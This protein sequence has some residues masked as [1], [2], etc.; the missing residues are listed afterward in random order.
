MTRDE[1]EAKLK[2]VARGKMVIKVED[3]KP[4]MYVFKDLGLD[5]LTAADFIIQLEDDFGF[6]FD[7]EDLVQI[8][9]VDNLI[10]LIEKLAA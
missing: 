2:E 4:E 10:G 6:E 8:Q 3:I 7:E 1:I 9:T 5:S